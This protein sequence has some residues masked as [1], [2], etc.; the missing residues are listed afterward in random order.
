M[1]RVID[2][3]IG[4]LICI[5]IAVFVNLEM[6]VYS[7]ESFLQK[8]IDRAKQMQQPEQTIPKVNPMQKGT[9]K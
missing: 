2:I 8:A 3:G 7:I 9:G 6:R 1:Q 4:I 5:V